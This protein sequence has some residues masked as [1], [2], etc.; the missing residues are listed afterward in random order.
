MGEKIRRREFLQVTVAGGA[1][2]A[3]LPGLVAT[4]AASGGPK[5]I[6][7]GC[8]RTKVRV[9]KI[10][11]GRP[12]AHWPTPKLDLQAEVRR[13]EAEFARLGKQLSDVQFVCSELVSSPQQVRQLADKLKDVD[14]ILAIHL[15]MGIGRILGEILRLGRPTVLFAAPYSG[16][17]WTS[18]GALRK[19][20]PLFDAILTSD[21]DQLA[22]QLNCVQYG[23]DR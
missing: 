4:G 13:Y 11:M 3:A 10:Y 23:M 16:H 18:Y 22:I 14:G 20:N 15:S 8:R 1:A 2:C 6:S 12:K 5:L 9:G 7:P 19:R 17:E 21:F